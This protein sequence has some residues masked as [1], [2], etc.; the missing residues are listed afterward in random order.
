MDK[1]FSAFWLFIWIIAQRNWT[2]LS[3]LTSLSKDTTGLRWS[4]K[5]MVQRFSNRWTI[6]FCH[7]SFWQDGMPSHCIC[8]ERIMIPSWPSQ[9]AAFFVAVKAMGRHCVLVVP[10]DFHIA[11]QDYNACFCLSKLVMKKWYSVF[12]FAGDHSQQQCFKCFKSF[13]CGC[14]KHHDWPSSLDGSL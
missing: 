10:V 1:F 5:M 4:G 3:F 11:E 12:H 13:T 6:V 14:I 8:W 2:A 7:C 9:G